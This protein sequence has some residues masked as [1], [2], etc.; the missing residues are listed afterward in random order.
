MGA[1]CLLSRQDG[2]LRFT[3]PP[4]NNGCQ[5]DIRMTKLKQKVSGCRRTLAGARQF[6]AIR[7]Y[8]ATAANTA[9]PSPMP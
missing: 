3:G 5:R 1:F 2:Y 7:S 9:S 4:D 6:R 8:L